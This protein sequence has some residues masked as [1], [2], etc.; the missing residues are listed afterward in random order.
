[1]SQANSRWQ[2]EELATAFLQGVRG[3]IP[4]ADLQLDVLGKIVHLKSGRHS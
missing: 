2:T 4:G 1:M 3:A